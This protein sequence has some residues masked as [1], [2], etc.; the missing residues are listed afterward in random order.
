M[1]FTKGLPI[2][3][4]Q[5]LEAAISFEEK[6]YT[7]ASVAATTTTGNRPLS[8]T[9]KAYSRKLSEQ[10]IELIK[11]GGIVA[12]AS[13]DPQQCSGEVRLSTKSF[14]RD[15]ATVAASALANVSATLTDVD[16]SD[17]IAGR[18]ED[19]ALDALRII[20]AALLPARLAWVNLSD[21]AL[22]EKGVRAAG[23]L[24]SKQPALEALSLQNVGCSIHACRAVEELLQQTT[25]LSSLQ[26][27]NNM[28]DNQGA[29]HIA[30]VLAH[31]PHMA[32]FRMASSRVGPSGGIALAKALTTGRHLVKLDISDNP[33][34]AAVGPALAALVLVQ[35]CLKILNVNDTSLTDKGAMAVAVALGNSSCQLEELEMALNEITPAGAKAVAAAVASKG[36]SLKR[37]NLRENELEDR[38]AVI[39]ARGLAK[40]PGLVSIDLC[41]NQLKRVGAVAVAKAAANSCAGLTLL[42]LDENTVSET[43][44]DE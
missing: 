18:P 4:D 22:G 28:S 37:V 16:I 33:M 9:T 38:G 12:A 31:S 10:V 29:L 1:G 39:I 6:A 19:E 7:A 15:A 26:L 11:A 25:S 17:I 2:S 14:G 34:T 20:S 13:Q 32:D 23:D 41:G 40:A 35:P 8:E 43:G 42:A 36:G 24:L 3:D 44:L 30:T 27:F 5:A 21:N